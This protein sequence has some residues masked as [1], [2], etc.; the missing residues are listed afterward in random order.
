MSSNPPVEEERAARPSRRWRRALIIVLVLANVLVLAVYL[1]LRSIE[2][3]VLETANTVPEVPGLTPTTPGGGDSITFLVIGSDSREGLDDLQYF[4]PVG[5]QRAD[6]IMLVKVHPDEDRAQILSLP[7]DLWV[8]IP[9]HGTNKIN[10]AY[11]LGGASLMVDTVA[12]FSDIP[13]N[14]YVEVDFVGFRALV[15]EI[16]GVTVD[17]PYPARDPKSGLGVGA[18]LQ[19]LDGS[20]ALAYARSRTYQEQRNGRWVSVDGGDFGRTRRQQQLIFAILS[21]LKR[22][23][24]IT[25][26]GSIVRA[27]ASH[28][29][30]DQALAQGS[31]IEMAF[32]MRG[33]A[34]GN[35]EAV[36]LPGVTA[37][38]GE[39]SV[40]LPDE[41]EAGQVLAAL[42]VG[43]P[44]VASGDGPM[45]VTVLN[46]NGVAG[47]ANA[48]SEHLAARGFEIADVGDALVKDYVE[49]RVRVRPA[50]VGR[51]ESIVE[52]LGFGV[53]EASTIDD[54]VDA[55]VVVGLDAAEAGEASSG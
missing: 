33:I 27:F 3:I 15:D 7:R 9:G 44:L 46:G 31:I 36:T 5:G 29:T 45:R 48:W 49:T 38:R 28:L 40:V 16:G 55:I 23:S 24:T 21:E 25:E 42:R 43:A 14:H 51:G 10:A 30:I 20:E 8:E 39:A 4:G 12:A 2:N 18:G 37:T 50:D 47:S 34:S 1:R 19:R 22:P 54:G 52:A 41:P 17:F 35:I 32:R 26:A 11:A 6:V 13:I 53:V